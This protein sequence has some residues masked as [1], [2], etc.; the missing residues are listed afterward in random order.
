MLNRL[1]K[2][3]FVFFGVVFWAALCPASSVAQVGVFKADP[4]GAVTS[5]WSWIHWWEANRE[6]FLRDTFEDEPAK[7]DPIELPRDL[8]LRGREALHGTL[9]AKSVDVRVESVLALARVGG[10]GVAEKLIELT[11]HKKRRIGRA[12]WLGLGLVGDE[13]AVAHLRQAQGLS[14]GDSVAWLHAVGLL[15][16]ADDELLRRVIEYLRQK[17]YDQARRAAAWVIRVQKPDF[18][19]E[20]MREA[21]WNDLDPGVVSEA[22]L[23]IGH[24]DVLAVDESLLGDIYLNDG[25]G[26]RVA[27]IQRLAKL[28]VQRTGR[29]TVIAG[30]YYSPIVGI[31]NAAAIAIGSFAPV[32][33]EDEKRRSKTLSTLHKTYAQ[34]VKPKVRRRSLTGPEYLFLDSGWTGGGGDATDAG[35]DAE[36]RFGLI[37][38][39]RLGSVR[40]A[41][42]LIEAVEG[43]YKLPGFSDRNTQFDPNRG[44]AAMGLGLYLRRAEEGALPSG[45]D[46]KRRSG[47]TISGLLDRLAEVARRENEPVDLRAACVLAMGMSGHPDAAQTIKEVLGGLQTPHRFILS[48]GVLA[49]GILEDRDAVSLAKNIVNDKAKADAPWPSVGT[50]VSRSGSLEA[51]KDIWDLLAL[52][53]LCTGVGLVAQP[54]DAAYLCRF[55]GDDTEV[56]R[57]A[58]SALKRVAPAEVAEVL[59]EVLLETDESQLHG[60]AA[61]GLGELLDPRPVAGLLRITEGVNFTLPNFKNTSGKSYERT[62]H[63]RVDIDESEIYLYRAYAQPFMYRRLLLGSGLRWR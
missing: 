13:S 4:N 23:S 12:A 32:G 25:D 14:Q 22:I 19:V 10:P 30:A 45:R 56:S 16:K 1:A 50:L 61:W 43:R 44:F 15:D 17:D 6:S 41:E 5:W 47:Q 54:D 38:M 26:R 29:G 11:G 39:G 9:E 55:I 34:A 51:F 28:N 7:A 48:H 60:L 3:L 27:S 62:F 18:A 58:I 8:V 33:L 52:R 36:R 37:A 40:E 20:L 42:R 24:P 63:K 31:R 2:T 21:V 35:G 59:I 53:A 46:S 49:L 57:Q